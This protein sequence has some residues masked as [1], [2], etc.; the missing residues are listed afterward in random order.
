LE[1]NANISNIFEKGIQ[2]IIS[3]KLSLITNATPYRRLH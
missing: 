2:K 1:K 3:M